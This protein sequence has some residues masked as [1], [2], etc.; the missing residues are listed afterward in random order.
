MLT[1]RIEVTMSLHLTFV[2]NNDTNQLLACYSKDGSTWSPSTPVQ[3]QASKAAPALA[4]FQDKLWVAFVA[5][6]ATSDLLVCSSANGQ[7]WS[8]STPVQGQA[9]KAAPAILGRNGTL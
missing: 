9:S 3:G 2:A 1:A 8:P 5:N 6:N 4:V 7:S